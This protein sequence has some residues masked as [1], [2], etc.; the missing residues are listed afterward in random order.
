MKK[1]N[2]L[3]FISN[4]VANGGAGRV[5]SVLANF[6]ARKGYHVSVYSYNNRYETYLLDSL[7]KQ[8][9][10]KIRTKQKLT[11]KLDR[12]RQLRKAFR[13]NPDAT[14][15]A[16]EYFVNM[17]TIIA[18]LGGR[19]KIIISERND[20]AQQDNRKIIKYMRDFLYRFAD[21]LVCQ[22]PDAKAYFPET[23]QKKTVVIPN[24]I[25]E[26]L[27]DLFR[28]ERKK[29]I[30]YFGRLERQKNLLLLIEAF[31]LLYKEHPEYTLSLYGDGCEKKEIESYIDEKR[32]LD[33]IS[34][35][36]STPDIHKKI[37]DCAMFV[38]SSDYEGLSNSML[39]AMALGLPCIVTDC[40][41]GGARTMIISYESGVLVPVRD[42]KAMVEAMKYI[43]ENPEKAALMSENATQV[44]RD[45]AVEK[46]AVEWERII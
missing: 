24:P 41:C 18:G 37:M 44:R 7:V 2:Q 45:L 17:Q 25:L 26:G 46:I 42:V 8:I 43:I 34:L 29:E 39:E 23:V 30:V 13:K 10:L 5:I 11:M 6:F 15:I 14:I 22:T 27:P 35:Q 20:P 1:G 21:V 31:A 28:G 40:P 12:I 38:S 9:F 36:G 16:F 4:E 19:N 32:L 3:I 33:C